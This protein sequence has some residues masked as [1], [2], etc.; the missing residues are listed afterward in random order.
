[1]T[2]PVDGFFSGAK[3]RGAF[4]PGAEPWTSG[5][6]LAS[7]LGTDISAA[8]GCPGDLNRDGVINATDFSLFVGAFGG[9]CF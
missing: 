3:Y 8:A 4:E 2:P 9:N 6:T 7:Q 1:L 5:W